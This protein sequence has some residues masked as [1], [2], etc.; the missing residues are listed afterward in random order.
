MEVDDDGIPAPENIPGINGNA[1]NGCVLF[2]WGHDGLCHRLSSGVQN[3]RASMK[4]F[5]VGMHATVLQLFELMLPKTFLQEVLLVETNKHLTQQLQY[6]EFLC[7]IGLWL[8]MATTQ[9]DCRRDFW[10]RKDIN[11][12]QGAPYRFNKYMSRFRFEAILTAPRIT[13][14]EAPTYVDR[15][16]EVRPLIKAWNENMTQQFLL[17][18]V[19]CLDESMSKWVNKYTCPGFMVVPRK[20]WPFGNEWHTICCAR[21]GVMFAVELM[22][23]KDKPPQVNKEF[24]NCGKMVGLLLR[25][26]CPIWHSS[27]LVILDSG[28]CVLKDIV[29][30]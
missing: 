27:R 2:P 28:F 16:W 19:T 25:L 21:S 9:F 4:H 15:F 5:P 6:G 7:W 30:L 13:K 26:T 3:F 20:P 10:S 8:M 12:F 22:E 11:M 29:E 24:S 14:D 23:G 1:G 18:S 17:S